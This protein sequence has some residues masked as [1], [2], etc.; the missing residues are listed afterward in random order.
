MADRP[1]QA[2]E[3]KWGKISR[4]RGDEFTLFVPPGRRPQTQR[5]FNF[6]YYH[7]LIRRLLAGKDYRHSIEF[8]CGR[9]TFSL[10]LNQYEGYDVELFDVSEEAMNLA[11]A[12]FDY[13]G[14][15]GNFFVADS[16]RVPKPDN[17]Y[18]LVVSMGLLE[19]QTDYPQTL[20]EMY[21]VLRPGGMLVTMNI[22]KKPSIQRLNDYYKKIL[23]LF[24]KKIEI[25]QG[26]FL[27]GA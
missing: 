13:H 6:Y 27:V 16:R 24:N 9:G 11:R 26:Y 14:A 12:N 17:H 4:G 23:R 21:R 5:Q 25:R 1:N 20:K 22:P 7:R 18:D 19:H 10:Y 3:E 8:G 15:I 2:F